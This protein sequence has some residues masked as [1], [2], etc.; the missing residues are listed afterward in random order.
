[1]PTAADTFSAEVVSLSLLSM[2]GEPRM[3]EADDT[4]G[5][6]T[7]MLTSGISLFSPTDGATTATLGSMLVD[8]RDMLVTS[9]MLGFSHFPTGVAGTMATA[10]EEPEIKHNKA[11]VDHTLPMLCT[12]ITPSRPIPFAANVETTE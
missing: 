3:P 2:A 8:T 12:P 5:S 6:P 10:V 1:M 7:S 11:I 4:R 9:D